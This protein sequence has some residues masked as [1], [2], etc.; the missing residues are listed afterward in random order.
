METTQRRTRELPAEPPC[1]SVCIAPML[2]GPTRSRSTASG[3]R[4]SSTGGP[5]RARP[6]AA[7][8]AA[9]SARSANGEARTPARLRTKSRPTGCRRPRGRA[10]SSASAWK[11]ARTATA[12]ARG[13]SWYPGVRSMSSAPSSARRRGAESVGN[14]FSTT[15]SKR[16]ASTTFGSPRSASAGRDESTRNPRSSALAS[17][18]VH[19]VDLPT[20]ATPSNTRP[21]TPRLVSPRKA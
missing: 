14:S 5:L 11:L 3:S 19:S 20:P 10:G 12:R 17:P 15:P 21:R 7:R 8:V 6:D 16:S 4:A 9:V 13:S 1:R 2:S 18:A